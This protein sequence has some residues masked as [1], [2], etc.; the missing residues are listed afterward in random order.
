M[1]VDC[2]DPDTTEVE[3]R[4]RRER[5]ETQTETYPPPL[6]PL[7]SP[8]S[9]NLARLRAI[10][11]HCDVLLVTA[12]QQKYRSARVADELAAAARGARLVF[13]QTHA[14]L[15]DDIREDWRAVLESKGGRREGEGRKARGLGTSVPVARRDSNPSPKQRP[16]QNRRPHLPH[17]LAPRLA[18]PRPACSRGGRWPICWTCSPAKWPAPRPTASAGRTSWIWWP[19]RWTP[20]AARLDEAMPGV[21]ETL[22]RHRPAAGLAGP[23]DRRRNAGRTAGQPAAV[24]EPPAGPGRLALGLQSVLAGAAG[25][26]RAGRPAGRGD[27]LSR[28]HARPNGPLGRLE[29]THTWRRW[30]RNRRDGRGLIGPPPPAGTPPNCA[31]PPSSSKGTRRRPDCRTGILACLAAVAGKDACPTARRFAGRRVGSGRGGLCRPRVGRPGIAGGPARPPPHRLVHPLALRNPP[32]RDAR[33]AVVPAGEELL[34]RL[35]A[36]G[37]ARRRFTASTSTSRPASGWCCGVWCCCGR[38]AAGCGA[39]CAAR[40]A[41]SPP[42]GK[43]PRRPRAC[44]PA[45]KPIAA[46]PSSSAGNSKSVGKRWKRC[47]GNWPAAV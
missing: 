23:A 15:D 20:A 38:F 44:S 5:P 3:E 28:P 35:L 25:V 7:P 10:L 9:S 11:P 37:A 6:S 45:S 16:D 17:R 46:A 29:G 26:S 47:G 27:A 24:G 13:V 1:L 2:P 32:G 4:G 41:N 18:T 8:L 31:R 22:V 39:G 34:L 40:S 30:R 21:R 14:D 19:T 42:A 12:T 36:G 33:A 43:T